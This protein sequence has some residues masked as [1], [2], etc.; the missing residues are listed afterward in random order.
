MITDTTIYHPSA[1]LLGAVLSVG[2]LRGSSGEAV[3]IAWI[4]GLEVGIRVASALG[5]SH[6]D[7][8]WHV[9]GTAGAVA[10]AAAAA[11]LLGLDSHRVSAALSIGATMSGGH[12]AHFGTDTKSGHAGFA[13]QKGVHAALLAEAGFTAAS[14]GI[15]GHAGLLQVVGPDGDAGALLRDLGDAWRLLGNRIKPYASGVVTHPSIDAGRALGERL[16][17]DQSRVQTVDLDV[18]PLAVELTGKTAPVTGLESKFSVNHLLRCR[19]SRRQSG[20]LGVF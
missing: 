1:A 7:R 13:A 17:H 5:M 19:I 2:Q 18:H 9:T 4:V 11:K 20:I 8:G 3:A 10:C 16:N 6:Y 12:R 15:F 14:D